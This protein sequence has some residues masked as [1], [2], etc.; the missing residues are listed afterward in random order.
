[1]DSIIS[2]EGCG[3][4]RESVL[5][6]GQCFRWYANYTQQQD[7]QFGRSAKPGEVP[8]AVYI[9]ATNK[10]LGV[11]YA[12]SGGY[13]DKTAIKIYPGAQ[14]LDQLPDSYLVDSLYVHPD[15]IRVVESKSDLALIKLKQS[16]PLDISG[17]EIRILNAICL[18]IK[19]KYLPLND[20][21]Q[22]ALVAGFGAY[23]NQLH[24]VSRLQVG[25]VY[26]VYNDDPVWY[27]MIRYP[28]FN[29][30]VICEGDSGGPLYQ[31]VNGRAVLIGIALSSQ[32]SNDN[33][34]MNQNDDKKDMFFVRI[35]PKLDWIQ[36][37]ISEN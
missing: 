9:S 23:G 10:F 19:T 5:M 22:L 18:P 35:A 34:C 15:Y 11:S 21:N 33:N 31:Y 37:V 26:L 12:Y 6:N 20:I 2:P 1:M 29:G 30:T 14:S 27:Y 8:F 4:G 24:T 17:Q 13:Y 16:I 7:I 25:W 3:V 36:Q 32:K 28:R